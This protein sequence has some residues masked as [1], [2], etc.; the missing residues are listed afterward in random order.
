[1]DKVRGKKGQL[2][3]LFN[4]EWKEDRIG[5]EMGFSNYKEISR[6]EDLIRGPGYDP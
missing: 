1:M 5:K 4:K 6:T 2:V 3:W